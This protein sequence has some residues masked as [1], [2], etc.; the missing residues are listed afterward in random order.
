MLL[1]LLGFFIGCGSSDS[2]LVLPKASDL[3]IGDLPIGISDWNP[4]GTPAGGMGALGLFYVSIDPVN[5]KSELTP[6]RNGSLTDVLE[7]VDITNFLTLAPCTKCVKIK[8]VGLDSDGHVVVSI[9]I[10]HPFPAGDPYKPITGRNRA[11]LHVFNVEG[12]VFANASGT[13]FSGIGETVA[14]ISMV[15][16]DG[17]TKYLDNSMDAIFPT[18]A[19]IHPY[20]LHFDDYSAGNFNPINP[21]GFASVTDPPPS[22][23]LVMAMGCDYNFQDYIYKLSTTDPIT[24][25]YA[26]GCT[27]AIS[28]SSKSLRFSPEYRIPQH[29]KKAASEVRVNIFANDLKEHQVTS[30]AT[31]E[32]SVLDINHGVPVGSEKNQMLADSSVGSI[33][34]EVP[35]VT[36][37]LVVAP[38][39][40]PISGNGWDPLNPLKFQV[41]ITN[42]ASAEEGF[43]PGLVKVLDTYMPGQNTAPSL[44]SKDGIKRVE[45]GLIPTSGLFNIDEFATYAVFTI[46]VKPGFV[47]DPP[48]AVISMPC[49]DN[50]IHA[51]DS[52]FFDGRFSTDDG[53]IVGFAW[54]FDWDLDPAHFDVESSFDHLNHT[55]GTAG[56][57]IAGLRV[58]DD[59]GQF[60][61]ETVNV[62]VLDAVT[63][64]WRPG[65]IMGGQPGTDTTEQDYLPARCLVVDCDGVV[66]CVIKNTSSGTIYYVNYN[67]SVVSAPEVIGN[68]SGGLAQ[69]T[70]EIDYDG[71]LHFLYCTG[72][73]IT[74][75]KREGGV[76]GTPE[77]VV[78]PSQIPGY[79]LDH[80]S[81]GVNYLCDRMVVFDKLNSGFVWYLAYVMNTGS[82]WTQ[83]VDITEFYARVDASSYATPETNVRADNDGRF[84]LIYKSWP[85]QSQI[86]VYHIFHSIYESGAWSTPNRFNQDAG[87]NIAIRE[88]IAPDGDVFCLWQTS[89]FGTF[90]GMYQRWDAGTETWGTAIRVTQN[91]LS[92]DYNFIP[93]ATVDANGRVVYAWEYYDAIPGN[94]RRHVYYKTFNELDSASTIYNAPRA[95]IDPQSNDNFATNPYAYLSIDGRT[96]IL[97][98]DDRSNP[99]NYDARDVYY[100]VWE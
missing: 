62:N 69:P 60:G 19:T 13:S 57:F 30:S 63:P 31:L 33:S 39:P 75:R 76:W 15:N 8:S 86:R 81:L 99:N 28:A 88:F 12:I 72:N 37:T 68:N 24:F 43:Y 61:Y 97:W 94:S 29:N 83:P 48:V 41:A 66:H 79:S 52:L 67:G 47:T 38:S 1:L 96:H 40:A 89:R 100:S 3:R 54:D 92:G 70:L 65:M 51:G 78:I 77:N 56:I 35:G 18:E 21:M 44:S 4:D 55:F 87:L 27:Y 73:A 26:V 25:I 20:K 91:V 71:N 53:S 32:I 11:D 5:L 74:Y 95:E 6:L 14:G 85:S 93:T 9:G 42:T 82:G 50:D 16:A 45:P 90:N 84:H 59:E 7:A 22:G 2:P 58:E 80:A 64:S 98:D 49:P 34:V 23:N 46:E 36:S 17:Y 10:K